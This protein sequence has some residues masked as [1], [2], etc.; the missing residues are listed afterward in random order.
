[1]GLHHILTFYLFAGCYV[2]NLWEIGGIIA[3]LHDIAD[4]ITHWCKFFSETRCSNFT[5]ASF[6]IY[7]GIWLYTRCLVFPTLIYGWVAYSPSLEKFDGLHLKFL[8]PVFTYLLLILL[9][10][11]WYWLHLFTKIMRKYLKTGQ[12]EDAQNKTAVTHS[13]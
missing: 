10:L 11:H 5:A 12:A 6:I 1:M 2:T 3:F 8:N 4:V 7:M 9:I 13:D